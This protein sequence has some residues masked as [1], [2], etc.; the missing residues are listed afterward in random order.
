MQS[1]QKLMMQVRGGS[2]GEPSP[3]MCS[4]L[5]FCVMMLCAVVCAGLG[6]VWRDSIMFFVVLWMMFAARFYLRESACV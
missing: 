4:S 3:D 1:S 5:L 2:G 6:R